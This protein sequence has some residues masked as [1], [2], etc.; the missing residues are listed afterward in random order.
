MNRWFDDLPLAVSEVVDVLEIFS[1][2]ASEALHQYVAHEY[3]RCASQLR[4][5]TVRRQ[6]SPGARKIDG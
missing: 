5:P 3:D 6:L 1:K 4:N 2:E